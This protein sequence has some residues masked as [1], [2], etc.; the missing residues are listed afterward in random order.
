MPM[1]WPA[2]CKAAHGEVLHAKGPSV[3][4]VASEAMIPTQHSN[5]AG[6]RSRPPAFDR[7][8]PFAELLDDPSNRQP[9]PD[10]AQVTPRD[11]TAPLRNPPGPR[12]IRPD[13]Q[14]SRPEVGKDCEL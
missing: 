9:A 4:R 1:G 3:S 11:P 10:Q 6:G 14:E 2:D 12:L 13:S 7:P 5:L 8:S